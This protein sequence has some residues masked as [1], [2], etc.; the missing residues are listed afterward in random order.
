MVP[1]LTSGSLLTGFFRYD[2]CINT[3]IVAQNT[4]AAEMT[5]FRCHCC[6]FS[7]H[8]KS[9]KESIY[10]DGRVIEILSKY[11]LHQSKRL[12]CVDCVNSSR[13]GDA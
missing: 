10:V 4:S 6:H 2:D 9:P 11:K 12:V 7:C 13:P 8:I 1:T 3:Y 5:I